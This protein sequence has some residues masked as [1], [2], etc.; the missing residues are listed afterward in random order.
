MAQKLPH[1]EGTSSCATLKS[2]SR[3]NFRATIS[4]PFPSPYSTV[5]GL[6]LSPLL[7]MANPPLQLLLKSRD[8][9]EHDPL[10][11]SRSFIQESNEGGSGRGKGGGGAVVP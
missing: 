7:G 6:P 2:R 1:G 8:G 11:S 3:S 10:L 9:V 4:A 5:S